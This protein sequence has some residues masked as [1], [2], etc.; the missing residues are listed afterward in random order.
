VIFWVLMANLRL[1]PPERL[2]HTLV[3]LILFG[4]IV[5]SGQLMGDS[6]RRL[7][8]A[9]ETGR[10]A[11]FSY[12]MIVACQLPAILVSPLAGILIEKHKNFRIGTYGIY[13]LI[14]LV[15]ALMNAF[16]LMQILRMRPIKER[17]VGEIFRDVVNENLMKV[18]DIIASPP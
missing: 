2:N 8:L 16:F 10:I 6:T 1:F 13:E 18:R 12:L 15:Y 11:F 17:P 14:F 4:G 9:P 5:G 7:G 3:V